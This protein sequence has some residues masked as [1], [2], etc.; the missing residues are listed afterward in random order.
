MLLLGLLAGL[1]VLA[2]L[3]ALIV[4]ETGYEC[5]RWSTRVNVDAYGGVSRSL[6]CAETRPRW[7]E[8]VGK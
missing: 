7:G 4:W 3:V 6:V 5:V 2:G 8:N 1:A